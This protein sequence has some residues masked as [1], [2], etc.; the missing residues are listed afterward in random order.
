[1]DVNVR[2]VHPPRGGDGALRDHDEREPGAHARHRHARE[3]RPGARHLRPVGDRGP[4]VGRVTDTRPAA[5]P[6]RLGR[7]RC[8]PTSP[9]SSLHEDAPSYHR[10]MARPAGLD[11][12]RRR[13]PGPAAGAQGLRRGPARPAHGSDVG[14]PPVRPPA[15]PEHRRRPRRRRRPPPPEGARHPLG[16]GPGPVHRRQRA[17][18]RPRPPPRHA[19]DRGRVGPQRGLRGRP[20]GRPGQLPQLRQSGAPRGHV[21]AVGGDRRHERGV[22]RPRHPRDRRQRQP[23][24]REPGPRHRPH[25]GRRHPRPGRSAGRGA[26]RR[27]PD[28]WRA[29]PAPR[30]P[31]VGGPGRLPVGFEHPGPPRRPAPLARSRPARPAGRPRRPAGQRAGPVGGP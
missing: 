31:G 24:Q 26:A 1:M 4:V 16:E 19:L 28:H 22:P 6:R 3:P 18:V 8:W 13:R 21:A 20:A 9:P 23:L 25:P 17:L 10:P 27:R 30:H 7:R 11:A 2:A 12:V 14:V 15:V 5:H 29:H